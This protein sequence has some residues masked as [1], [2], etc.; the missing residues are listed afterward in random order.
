MQQIAN[1]L[2]GLY[3][4]KNWMYVATPN[5]SRSRLDFC[6]SYALFLVKRAPSQ[7]FREEI[8]KTEERK[9]GLR[10]SIIVKIKI[11]CQSHCLTVID[12]V[13][14]TYARKTDH[15]ADDAPLTHTRSSRKQS[16]TFIHRSVS[17]FEH[18]LTLT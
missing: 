1:S 9:G 4:L 11:K 8:K 6:F 10:S 17:I 14:G 18:S 16:I 13:R 5:P 7:L 2:P 12:E 15:I 3:R